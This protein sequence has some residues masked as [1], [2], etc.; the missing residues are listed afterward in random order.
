MGVL[1][2]LE[3]L[4]DGSIADRNFLQ[5]ANLVI[6]TGGRSLGIRFGS[7]TVSFTAA[8]Q[9]ANK[10]ISHGLG[11]TPILV[12]GIVGTQ[13]MFLNTFTYTD[14]TFTASAYYAAG[15]TTGNFT[16]FWVAIG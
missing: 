8:A 15:T 12:L 1:I 9:S 13:G 4:A 5:L 11:K 2:G 16:I 3:H 10:V 7:D 6:D 14:T